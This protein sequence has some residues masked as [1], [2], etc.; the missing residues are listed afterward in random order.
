MALWYINRAIP[1]STAIAAKKI[2]SGV[3]LAKRNLADIVALDVTPSILISPLLQLDIDRPRKM[4]TG[5]ALGYQMVAVFR[6]GLGCTLA[7]GLPYQSLHN[8]LIYSNRL[9]YQTLPIILDRGKPWPDGDR[10]AV[11]PS[12]Q[13]T[14]ADRLAHLVDG[15]F[16][17]GTCRAVLVVYRGRLIAERYAPSFTAHTSLEGH[18]IGLLIGPLLV[19]ALV[20]ERRL[21]LSAS[22][23]DFLPSWRQLPSQD[24][25][26]AITVEHLLMMSSGLHFTTQNTLLSD[27]L[28]AAFGVHDAGTFCG[29]RRMTAEPGKRWAFSPCNAVLLMAV[30][31]AVVGEPRYR[32]F[33][34][35]ALFDP[36]AMAS[37]V[38]EPDPAGTFLVASGAWATARDWA[39]LGLAYT[40]RG[41]YAGRQVFPQRWMEYLASPSPLAQTFQPL[42]RTSSPELSDAPLLNHEWGPG[43]VTLNAGPPGHPAARRYPRLPTDAMLAFGD[44]G[45][46]L[47]MA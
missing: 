19:G 44:H 27:T 15:A 3:F 13:P 43:Q 47:L 46:G 33:T 34:R 16:H 24:P 35:A 23:A 30:V 26:R 9:L 31:R 36:L 14:A 22:V 41:R 25:R 40:R 38:L 6:E 42:S 8:Q 1:V 17:S 28:S 37:A 18:S 2:C 45:T 4:V 12:P 10:P 39:R 7:I 32:H 5:V 29:D 21:S 11:Q 20:D